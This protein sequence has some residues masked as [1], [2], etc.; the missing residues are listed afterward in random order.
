MKYNLIESKEN[1]I[2]VNKEN[3]TCTNTVNN[4]CTNINN[5][6]TSNKI[7]N[8]KNDDGIIFNFNSVDE[9]DSNVIQEKKRKMMAALRSLDEMEAKLKAKEETV[10]T[11]LSMR[12][13]GTEDVLGMEC[14][15]NDV[16]DDL[17]KKGMNVNI[18]FYIVE[19]LFISLFFAFMYLQFIFFYH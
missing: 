15:T 19:S 5:N 7:M 14:T 16:T 17:L 13:T 4:T 1:V 11:L 6:N 9:Y 3:D 10:Q 2:L 18:F 12:D 8:E